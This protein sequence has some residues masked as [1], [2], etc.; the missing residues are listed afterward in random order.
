MTLQKIKKYRKKARKIR[1][2]S[3]MPALVF[4]A[5]LIQWTFP[6][7]TLAANINIQAGQ[8]ALPEIS[9]TNQPWDYDIR[10]PKVVDRQPRYTVNIVVT[11][12]NSLPEQTDDTPCITASGL[13]VCER[14][15]EDIVATNF[16]YLPF[17]TQVRF[18]DL[19]GDR[20]FRI[21]DR[22]NSRYYQ[23]ADVWMKDY[24]TAKHFG[25]R[26]TKMEVF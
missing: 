16:A 25:K 7:I 17:G 15:A 11:A 26:W 8:P 6:Q 3:L 12:Y 18:P 21:E 13:N 10:L 9:V 22:M 23:R 2:K 24:Q 19:F 14:D 1:R 20:I 5:M 4:M